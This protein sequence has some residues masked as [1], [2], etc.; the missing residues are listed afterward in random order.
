M[1]SFL[2]FFLLN[3]ELV[4]CYLILFFFFL[5]TE[6]LTDIENLLF[7]HCIFSFGLFQ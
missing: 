3:M 4:R 6:V 1:D 2:P 7:V 5:L